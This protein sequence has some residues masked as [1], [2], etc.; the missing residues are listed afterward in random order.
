[1]LPLILTHVNPSNNLILHKG[2][3]NNLTFK[4]QLKKENISRCPNKSRYV[5]SLL[6]FLFNVERKQKEWWNV[7]EFATKKS[8]L[9]M[10]DT[11]AKMIH[12]LC[13]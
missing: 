8:N 9:V 3:N 6:Y 5:F 2:G 10:G 12:L 4:P 1:M 11:N 13:V 7:F